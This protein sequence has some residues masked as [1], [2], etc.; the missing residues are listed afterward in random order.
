MNVSVFPTCVCEGIGVLAARLRH[1]LKIERAFGVTLKTPVWG[2]VFPGYD[3]SGL[4]FSAMLWVLKTRGE[5]FL[6]A[7]PFCLFVPPGLGARCRAWT[8]ML[9]HL[10]HLPSLEEVLEVLLTYMSWPSFL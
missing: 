4:G 1:L 3:R 5:K 10:S 9:F 7:V 8:G 6:L 2:R